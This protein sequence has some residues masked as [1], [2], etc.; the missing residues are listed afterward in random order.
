MSTIAKSRR[1]DPLPLPSW[2]N[3]NLAF[4]WNA[5]EISRELIAQTADEYRRRFD[6]TA[7]GHD[8]TTGLIV[9]MWGI[10]WNSDFAHKS[11]ALPVTGLSGDGGKIGRAHV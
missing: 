4:D 2:F 9:E 6:V 5:P 11:G 10:D 7:F 1:L 8:L 3:P